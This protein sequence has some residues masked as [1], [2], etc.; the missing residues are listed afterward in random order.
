[1][2]EH[3]FSPRTV[4]QILTSWIGRAIEA[5]VRWATQEG[6][7]PGVV[8]R[9]VPVVVQFGEFARSRGA[10]TQGDLPA[11]KDAFVARWVQQHA[12]RCCS[13]EA[14]HVVRAEAHAAVHQ[15][16]RLVL[17][18]VPRKHGALGASWP[19]QDRAPGFGDHL[20]HDRG[21]S[22]ETVRGH[23]YHLLRFE[24]Y[25][26]RRKLTDL[27]ELS[28][29]L[30]AGFMMEDAQRL[31]TGTLHG[32][33]SSL[34][35][36]GRYLH[37]ERICPADLSRVV[38]RPRSYRLSGIPR[39]ISS[40]EV[41]RV[42]NAIARDTAVGK[43]DY[44]M[45]LL[46][47]AYG[48]RAREVAAL[49]FDDLDWKRE[50]FRV[51]ERKAGHSTVFPLSPLVGAALIDYI[52]D[53]R[54]RSPERRVFLRLLP[55]FRAVRP[56]LVSSRAAVALRRAGVVVRRGG[57][58]TF[59]HSCVQRLVDAEFPFKVIGDY[60]GHRSPNSTR[61]YGKVAV[62]ALRAVAMGDGEEVL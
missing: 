12:G 23:G 52:R 8:R 45:L 56:H 20:I 6:F 18:D 30:L 34:R 9:R 32:R 43:R 21:L 13:Q 44:A 51:P 60:V 50:R 39:S 48:L 5:Y 53:A 19:F 26:R 57:S 24:S 61:I 37:R 16:L 2:L 41:G 7:A 54:P 27:A 4:D 55:P 3:Y 22:P 31:S 58:H 36:F 14:L 28:P 33:C 38:E 29:A 49:T 46:L 25:L 10:R 1:M 59:R 42:L 62:E 47:V 17:A 40:D 15:L 11:F 35:A